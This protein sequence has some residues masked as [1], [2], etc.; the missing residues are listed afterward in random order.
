MTVLLRTVGGRF[1]RFRDYIV[2]LQ[3]C[4]AILFRALPG[5]GDSLRPGLAGRSCAQAVSDSAT[6]YSRNAYFTAL[7]GTE[8][9]VNAA[10]T[11]VDASNTITPG[12]AHPGVRR[13][14]RRVPPRG[15][16][17]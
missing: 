15:S 6:R 8:P 10:L 9:P 13:Y 14:K 12:A 5:D 17:R 3:A 16:R 1:S 11:S 4:V 7:A 2:L